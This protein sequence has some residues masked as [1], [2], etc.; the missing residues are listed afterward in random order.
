LIAPKAGEVGG[1]A[2]FKN[3]CALP[4]RNS[5]RILAAATLRQAVRVMPCLLA[6]ASIR[7]FF[8]MW[9]LIGRGWSLAGMGRGDEGVALLA[10]GLAG[11]RDHGFVIVRLWA[12]TLLAD[13]CRMAGQWRAA[14]AHLAEAR[15]LAEEKEV[16]WLQAETLRL[17]GD[18]LLATGDA[19]AAEASY[20]DA[21]GVKPRA[22]I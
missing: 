6:A 3:F 12:L 17:T 15:G 5:E 1:G 11:L 4:F 7:E 9:G 13:A 2:K 20:R 8:R 22:V 10:V 19:A 16:R 21:R 14:L 18:V